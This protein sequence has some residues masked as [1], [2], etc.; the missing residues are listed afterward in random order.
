MG[1]KNNEIIFIII[2]FIGCCLM[3]IALLNLQAKIDELEEKQLEVNEYI[4]NK[5][6]APKEAYEKI[7]NNK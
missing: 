4:F 6:E 1:N 5:I 7:Q 3:A 2:L